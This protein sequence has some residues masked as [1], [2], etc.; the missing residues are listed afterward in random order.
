[1]VLGLLGYF[2]LKKRPIK[3][4]RITDTPY[5]NSVFLAMN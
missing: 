2:T 1:M 3:V 4:S 5:E